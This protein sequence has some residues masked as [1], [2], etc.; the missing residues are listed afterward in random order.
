MF[1]G[2]EARS[3]GRA[4]AAACQSVMGT[5]DEGY[6]VVIDVADPV[7]HDAADNEAISLVDKFLKLYKQNPVVTVANTIFPQALYEAH[8][9]P[10]FYGVYHRDFDR[11]SREAKPWGQYF[12]RMTRWQVAGGDTIHPLQ[13]L[14]AKLKGNEAKRK[15]VKAIYELAVTG[16]SLGRPART[17]AEEDDEDGDLTLYSPAKDRKKP[18]SG[19]CLSYLSFKRHP[20]GDLLLTAVYRNHYYMT[21][22][23]G[24]LI[25]LGWLQAFV[26]KEAGLAVG[27]LTVLST[28][29]VL[30]TDGG[31]RIDEARE[32]VR[33]AAKLSHG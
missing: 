5:K 4:W 12:D 26:A 2:V 22:L 17:E 8:G 20:D 27:S 6:N 29:A 11:F 25:G 10:A 24:N 28:H 18:I 3:C 21:K 32:L 23:L 15:R 31:W 16:P 1:R 7:R 19:P 30:D 13:D 14:I 9:S 33:Q